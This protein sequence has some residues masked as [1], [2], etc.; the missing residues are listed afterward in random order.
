MFN[1]VRNHMVGSI[2]CKTKVKGYASLLPSKNHSK[3][4][5]KKFCLNGR[6][7]P[8][9][10]VKSLTSERQFWY[11]SEFY[12]GLVKPLHQ[13]VRL[14]G[15]FGLNRRVTWLTITDGALSLIFRIEVDDFLVDCPNFKDMFDFLWSNLD[16]K[17]INSNFIDGGA[18]SELIR[19]LK[20]QE[21][22]QLLPGS[23]LIN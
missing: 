2:I 17:T 14:M 19:N 22:L 11:I 6:D 20:N 1:P 12:P 21:R 5:L 3:W 10:F 7:L 9:V 4:L 18:I 16:L 8:L 13:L 15:N 23:L